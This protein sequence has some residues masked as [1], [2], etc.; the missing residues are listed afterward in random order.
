MKKKRGSAIQQAPSMAMATKADWSELPNDLLNLISQRIDNEIDLIRFRSIC[1]HWRS[2]SIPNYHRDMLTI[3]FLL[4]EFPLSKH[5][6]FLIKP[7]QVRCRRPPWLLRITQNSAG[8]TQFHQ[9]LRQYGLS[10]HHEFVCFD[11]N[12]F[13][14]LHLAIT[15]FASRNK[16]K[17]LPSSPM[18]INLSFSAPVPEENID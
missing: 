3:K 2:S 15:S 9:P 8:K 14:L 12:R 18:E 10:N 5:S 1:S 6:F 7:P 13:S 4:F 11:F 16:Q 17:P